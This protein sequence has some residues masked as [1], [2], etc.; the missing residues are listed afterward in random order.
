[1]AKFRQN[2]MKLIDSKVLEYQMYM[3]R[4]RL[5][6]DLHRF[7]RL[8]EQW[9]AREREA[10]VVD[11]SDRISRQFRQCEFRHINKLYMN[12]GITLFILKQKL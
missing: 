4:K 7:L 2:I 5:T 10:M 12:L 6:D 3:S 9:E 11:D 1:M 8:G